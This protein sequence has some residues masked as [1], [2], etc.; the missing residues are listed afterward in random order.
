MEELRGSLAPLF[1]LGLA[2]AVILGLIAP[3]RVPGILGRF[4]LL[5]LLVAAL[6]FL[7]WQS[8][9]AASPWTQLVLLLTLG[10]VVLVVLLRLML[11]QGLFTHILGDLLYDLLKAAFFG[12]WRAGTALSRLLVHG[13]VGHGRRQ[14]TRRRRGRTRWEETRRNAPWERR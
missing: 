5:P 4:F 11:G 1:V 12:A 14:Q 9:R 7:T 3:R 8:L 13:V 6:L 2:L 10:P